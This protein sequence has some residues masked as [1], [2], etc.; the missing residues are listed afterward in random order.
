VTLVLNVSTLYYF[1]IVEGK[2]FAIL[3]GVLAVFATVFASL[4]SKPSDEM[5]LAVV[6][7]RLLITYDSQTLNKLKLA[8]DEEQKLRDFIDYKSNEIFYRRLR[9]YLVDEL[10]R[11]YR[12]S[13]ISNLIEE[14]KNVETELDR[15]NIDYDEANLPDRFKN[16]LTHLERKRA[17]DLMIEMVDALPFFP[18][19]NMIKIYF[20][21]KFLG[22]VRIPDSRL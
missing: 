12:D 10:E 20:K 15:F 3:S 11:K 5:D 8:K 13:E 18:F 19:K 14:I 17:T 1:D 2:W 21:L 4:I 9:F 22:D 16:F 7:D 6:A